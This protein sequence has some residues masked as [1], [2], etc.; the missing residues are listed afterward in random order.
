MK[1]GKLILS[2]ADY[3]TSTKTCVLLLLKIGNLGFFH[4]N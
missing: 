2:S 4:N 3:M 1:L